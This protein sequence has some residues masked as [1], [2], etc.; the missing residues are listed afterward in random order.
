MEIKSNQPEDQGTE[1][2]S[3]WWLLSRLNLNPIDIKTRQDKST[4]E[5]WKQS[6][7]GQLYQTLIESKTFMNW[8]E[9]KKQ[10]DRVC[11]KPQ[12]YLGQTLEVYSLYYSTK[13]WTGKCIKM[14]H[15]ATVKNILLN[16]KYTKIE[17]NSIELKKHPGQ[18]LKVYSWHHS[19]TCAHL[20]SYSI[21]I[22]KFPQKIPT[23]TFTLLMYKCTL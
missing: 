6:F 2:V 1:S 14:Y 19:S 22:W 16:G 17:R 5:A 8:N 18:T 13:V 12:L 7:K 10:I 21:K 15:T 23:F 9:V 4:I 20:I 3:S 11:G